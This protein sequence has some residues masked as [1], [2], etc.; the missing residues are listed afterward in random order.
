M[1]RHQAARTPS[2]HPNAGFPEPGQALVG[3]PQP[4]RSLFGVP[5]PATW[6]TPRLPAPPRP[7]AP[8]DDYPDSRAHRPSLRSRRA[9][10]RPR[11]SWLQ[12]LALPLAIVTLGVALGVITVVMLIAAGVPAP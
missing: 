6:E 5:Q 10:Q 1:T 9:P 12:L 2:K 4:Q 11:R 7:R 8:Q 3:F